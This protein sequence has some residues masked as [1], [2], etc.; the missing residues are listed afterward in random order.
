MNLPSWPMCIAM[1]FKFENSPPMH[2][3]EPPNQ[4]AHVLTYHTCVPSFL[5]PPMLLHRVCEVVQVESRYH[6]EGGRRVDDI[7]AETLELLEWPAICRQVR[8]SCTPFRKHPS[9]SLSLRFILWPKSRSASRASQTELNAIPCMLK[10]AHLC[11][12]F[13]LPFQQGLT[14]NGAWVRT[15]PED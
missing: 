6:C 4:P 7:E 11:T 5:I 10:P 2:F 1:C 15:S 13:A 8:L 9:Q 14:C 3:G 12:A